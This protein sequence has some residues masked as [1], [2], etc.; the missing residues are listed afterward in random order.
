MAAASTT[1]T[2]VLPPGWVRIA[3]N[4][5]TERNIRLLIADA[6]ASAPPDQAAELRSFLRRTIANAVARARE[7]RATDVILSRQQAGS[8]AVP[9]S[10]IVARQP[11]KT[12]GDQGARQ[13]LIALAMRKDSDVVELDGYVAVRRQ[14]YGAATD[15]SPAHRSVSYAA[16]LPPD[17]EWIVFTAS[18]VWSDDPA[19][20]PA[21]ETVQ[22]LID[23]M[24]STVRFQSPEVT[25]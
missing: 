12:A 18:V 22:L 8:I 15:D 3:V 11:N 10:I 13:Q 9:A 20:E 7:Q 4:D 1:F 16:Y 23:T 24:M 21:L 5:Q 17:D 19:I 25:A 6:V 14:K 2:I